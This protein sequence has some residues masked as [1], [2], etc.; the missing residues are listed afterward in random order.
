MSDVPAVT[1]RMFPLPFLS[2]APP[3][4]PVVVDSRIPQ[5]LER[6]GL[7]LPEG[8]VDGRLP[9]GHLPQQLFQHLRG[10]SDLSQDSMARPSSSSSSEGTPAGRPTRRTRTS[11][12]ARSE[13]AAT[14]NSA[15]GTSKDSPAAGIL[16]ASELE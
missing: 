10:Q 12:T 11:F 1:T 5:A 13:A 15:P 9:L 16:P 7:D 2:P 8:G 4:R 14:V 3:H 6:K